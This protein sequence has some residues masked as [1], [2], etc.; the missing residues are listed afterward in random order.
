MKPRPGLVA[1]VAP[2]VLSPIICR[3]LAAITIEPVIDAIGLAR[4]GVDDTIGWNVGAGIKVR[5]PEIVKV[6]IVIA[7]GVMVMV[8]DIHVSRE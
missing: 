3:R 5:R 2:T 4:H 1:G 8:P 7:A 6:D